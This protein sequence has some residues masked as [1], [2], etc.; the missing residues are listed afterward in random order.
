MGAVA[1]WAC[2]AA[3]AKGC[4]IFGGLI[5][6]TVSIIENAAVSRACM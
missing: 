2:S 1:G 3:R 5:L 4:V 6:S